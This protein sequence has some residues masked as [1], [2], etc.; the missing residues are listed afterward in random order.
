MFGN[1]IHTYQAT[2]RFPIVQNGVNLPAGL[3][4]DFLYRGWN[5]PLSVEDGRQAIEDAFQRRWGVSLKASGV[6][7][8]VY[9]KVEK[10]N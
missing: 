7:F 10:L 1:L 5:W 4:V 6:P 8:G 9:L 3:S 2:L